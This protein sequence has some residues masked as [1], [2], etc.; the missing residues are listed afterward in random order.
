MVQGKHAQK[1]HSGESVGKNHR[2]KFH[3]EV[4][5]SHQISR[6]AN[7][8]QPQGFPVSGSQP[9]NSMGLITRQNSQPVNVTTHQW[10]SALSNMGPKVHFNGPEHMFRFPNHFGRFPTDEP[11]Q[12]FFKPELNPHNPQIVNPGFQRFFESINNFGPQAQNP[13]EPLKHKEG[14]LSVTSP[15]VES[16]SDN[17]SEASS[18]RSSASAYWPAELRFPTNT[19]QEEFET[20]SRHKPG[21][22][23][24]RKAPGVVRQPIGHNPHHKQRLLL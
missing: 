23:L 12:R 16:P 13:F 18:I 2:S 22:K 9:D 8:H 4:R 20:K 15:Q 6:P 1:V 24:R 17:E 10:P 5:V 7:G 19:D 14:Q 3:S 11:M 21:M